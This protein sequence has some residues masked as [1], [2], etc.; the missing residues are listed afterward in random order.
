[1]HPLLV[2]H[3]VKP[4]LNRQ[5]GR[6]AAEPLRALER[7]QWFSPERLAE[8][9]WAKVS[10]LLRHAYAHVPFYRGLFRELGARP[11]DF[12]SLA[13]LRQLP[14]LSKQRVR[15]R[16]QE[17]IAEGTTGLLPR[18]TSGSTG[19]PLRSYI[20]R[21]CQDWWLAAER[22][23]RRWWG[24]DIGAREATLSARPMHWKR[25]LA[26]RHLLNEAMV[27][28]TDLSPDGLTRVYRTLVRFRPDSLRGTPTRLA[29]LARFVLEGPGGRSLLQPKVAWC[30]AE[31]LY[32]DQQETILTAFGGAVVN[33]YGSAENELL[34]VE[35]PAG[36]MHIMAENHY[37]EFHPLV[38]G[39]DSI[40]QIVVTDLNNYG[41]P[42]IRYAIGD[43]GKAVAG[44]CPCGRG[45]PLMEVTGGRTGDVVV[46][47][48]G[49]ILASAPLCHAVERLGL[50]RLKQ[51][52]VVQ[53]TP[54]SFTVVM[55][56][57]PDPE[58]EAGIR[59]R[60]LRYLG[61]GP[62]VEFQSVAEIPMEA[63]G[64]LRRFV[65]RVSHPLIRHRAPEQA[66]GV[67]H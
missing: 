52:Q 42:F 56:G 36:R 4:L 51:Y 39:N 23:R 67:Y 19:I 22:R 17:L 37:L 66:P 62:S 14:L 24:V 13:D 55:V 32:P 61:S 44:S 53:E 10:A 8:L 35:C 45:L 46:L 16:A 29:H 20:D 5:K 28:C 15:D 43:L 21:R 57:E 7:S 3:V 59:A 47:S 1:M 60:F 9:Q 33:E 27:P 38:A 12:R 63:S 18:V 40:T 11:E 41:M 34:A 64:K 2:R 49:R 30:T 48:D 6:Q 54:G 65:S 31:V 58:L 25:A 50:G 26:R